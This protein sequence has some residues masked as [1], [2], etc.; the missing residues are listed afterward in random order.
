MVDISFLQKKLSWQTNKLL[1]IKYKL[2]DKQDIK[3]I[4]HFVSNNKDYNYFCF[5]NKVLVIKLNAG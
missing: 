3:T 5:L 4:E 2:F 1:N